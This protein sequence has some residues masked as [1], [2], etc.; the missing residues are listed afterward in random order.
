MASNFFMQEQEETQTGWGANIALSRFAG[1]M[2]GACAVVFQMKGP[3]ISQ[4]KASEWD[5]VFH[6]F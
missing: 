5:R 6:I 2:T 1:S 3:F 4:G